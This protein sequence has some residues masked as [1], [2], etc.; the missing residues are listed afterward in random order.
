MLLPDHW[1]AVTDKFVKRFPYLCHAGIMLPPRIDPTYLTTNGW[2]G[3]LVG[4]SAD[5]TIDTWRGR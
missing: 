2:N 1:Y 5:E 3:P 4:L